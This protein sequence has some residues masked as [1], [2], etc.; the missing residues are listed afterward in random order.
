MEVK[1]S[2]M[3]KPV[4][5]IIGLGWI[6]LPLGQKLVKSGYVVKGSTTTPEKLESINALAIEP[7]QMALQP[8]ATGENLEALFDADIIVINIPPKLRQ[9][10]PEFHL[11]QIKS[12]KDWIENGTATKLIFVSATSVYLEDA[13]ETSEKIQLS[14]ETTGN[15]TLLAAE[16]LLQTSPKFKTTILRMGGLMG[17][18]RIPGKYF[19]GKSEVDGEAPIN[20]LH[21]D[22]AVGFIMHII[23]N[24]VWNEVYNVVAP[25]FRTR[26]EVLEKNV[27]DLGMQAIG[28]SK[29]STEKS[30]RISTK[31]IIESG[32]SFICP[33]PLDFYYE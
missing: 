33:D 31:K 28:Y 21:Q 25:V 4:V 12:L 9:H 30:R 10:S 20:Y 5:S 7:F 14:M 17:Y 24:Q 26:K 6:G 2:N 32:Y 16:K 27:K 19:A 11:A 18:Q 8:E 29:Q 23:E 22:D 13:V 3:S 15:P 1:K